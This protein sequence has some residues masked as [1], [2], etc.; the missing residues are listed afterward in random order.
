MWTEGWAAGS[1]RGE[2]RGQS[3]SPVLHEGTST[4]WEDTANS[5]P[6]RS[7][8]WR[9]RQGGS[10]AAGQ[11]QAS[12]RVRSG[13]PL[14]EVP[15]GPTCNRSIWLP[16]GSW[17]ADRAPE[18]GCCQHPQRG[19]MGSKQTQRHQ[20]ERRRYAAISALQCVRLTDG[21]ARAAKDASPG[22]MEPPAKQGWRRRTWHRGPMRTRRG[23]WGPA[24]L[25]PP[26]KAQPQGHLSSWLRSA[27]TLQ[28]LLRR[29]KPGPPCLA[30]GAGSD[31][32]TLG[33]AA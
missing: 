17:G 24:L 4:P 23:T 20:R 16:R 7:F 25:G 18:R 27:C 30:A 33:T 31:P 22:G 11:R 28:P 21:W 2:P 12:W 6:L 14:Q 3:L 8:P 13:A 19:L 29:G 9:R 10:P 26:G 1:R 32:L 15:S 5:K